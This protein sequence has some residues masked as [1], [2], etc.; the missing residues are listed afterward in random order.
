VKT[1]F[2]FEAAEKLRA[3]IKEAGGIEVFAIGRMGLDQYVADLDVHCRGN[4]NSVPAL[5][6]TPRPGEVVIH[7]HPSGVMEASGP[8]MQLAQ[9]YGDDGIGVVIV[10]NDVRKALWVVEPRVRRVARLDPEDVRQFFE[11]NIPRAI[12]GYEQRDGQLQMAMDVAHAFNE[13]SVSLLEAGTGTGKSLAYLVPAGLWALNNDARVA[14][15]T[16]T[17]ALQGQLIRSDLA[18]LKRA[19][20]DIRFAAMMGRSNYLCKRKLESAHLDP[21]EEDEARALQQIS[22]W[23]RTTPDGTRADLAFPIDE[24]DWDKVNSD[25]DQTLRVRCPHYDSCHY[26]EARRAAADAHILVVNHHL[27]MADLHTKFDSGGVGV[28]PRYDRIVLDE[29]HH[30]EDAA[31]LLFEDRLGIEGIRRA[32]RPLLPGRRKRL[33]TFQKIHR[34][35]LLGGGPLEPDDVESALHHLG[36]VEA[37]AQ[38]LMS[39]APVWMEDIGEAAHIAELNTVRTPAE[40]REGP[41]WNERIVPT[42]RTISSAI[43]R[44]IK[45][46]DGL[47]DTLEALPQEVRTRDT[48]LLF[49][50]ARARRRLGDKAKSASHFHGAD[51]PDGP[52]ALAGEEQWVSW[53]ARDRGY[54]AAPAV[55]LCMAPIDVGPLLRE[56]V[57]EAMPATVVTSATLTV[58]KQFDHLRSRI[59]LLDC[60]RVETARYP[61]PFNYREQALLGIPRDLPTPKEAGFEERAGEVILDAIE[62]ADGGTFVLC[63]SYALV[64]AFHARAEA[65]FGDAFPLLKQ[66]QMSRQRLLDRYKEDRRSVLFGTDSFWEGID[67]KGDQLRQVIIP[68]LPFRVPTEPIQQARFERLEA[69]GLDPFRAYSLPQAVLRFRQGFGRLIRTQKDRGIVLVLDRRVTNQWYGRVFLASLPDVLRAQGPARAVLMRIRSAVGNE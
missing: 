60:D 7:N 32:V 21:G 3:A 30:L 55:R 22:D 62:A 9:L 17:I 68:R 4:K 37:A 34:K 36:K 33:G 49:E 46:L 27:L 8:D 11:E 13:G 45:S 18:I 20:M 48:Q 53:L 42:L 16:F 24:Q 67:V 59:G 10:D 19:G 58:A 54:R 39:D 66:G 43:H 52:D 63:T 14:V 5:L 44:T 65:K 26:Y 6:R 15:S 69:Q 40:Y 64:D 57:F 12:A 35:Y 2:S 47:I 56:R 25:A 1:R 29:G 41:V 38:T 61:S 50:L 23:A 28:L 31:T 51:T